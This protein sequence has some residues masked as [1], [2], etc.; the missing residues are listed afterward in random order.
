MPLKITTKKRPRIG[1]IVEFIT[2]NGYAY[3]QYTHKHDKPPYWGPLIRILPGIYES[4]LT[5][6]AQLVQDNERFFIFYPLGAA[7]SQGLAK[8]V[9]HEEVPERYRAFPIFKSGTPEKN[10]RKVV[11]WWLW[12]GEKEWCVGT[13]KPEQYDLPLAEIVGH[14]I[15]LSRIMSGWKPSDEV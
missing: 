9:G 15:L 10:T 13:L 14:P 1:D 8:I 3:A 12:D 2:P 11:T 6:F 5:D 7:V 4:P